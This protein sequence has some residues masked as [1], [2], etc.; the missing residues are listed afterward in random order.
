MKAF[1]I[2]EGYTP[3]NSSS[4]WKT[5]IA[6]WVGVTMSFLKKGLQV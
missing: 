2:K 1:L 4:Q 6:E 5:A 3:T